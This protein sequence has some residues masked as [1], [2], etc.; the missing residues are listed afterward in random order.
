MSPQPLVLDGRPL[1]FAELSR[2]GE[3]AISLAAD[4][5]ALAAVADSRHTVEG[6]IGAGLPVYGATTGVGAMKDVEW[7]PEDLDTFNMGLVRAHHFG[8]GDPFP[9][10]VVRNAMAIRVNTAPIWPIRP[11][12]AQPIEPVRRTTGTTSASSRER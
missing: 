8:T 1:S 9:M 3:H 7:S 5:R 2:I 10:S 4:S 11:I 6:R 12:S